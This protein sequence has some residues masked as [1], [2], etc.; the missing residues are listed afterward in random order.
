MDVEK[1]LKR[2]VRVGTVTDID[3]AKRKARVKF[4]DCNMTSGWLYVLDTHPHIPAY[5]PA[6]QKTELQDGHQHDL[7]IKPWMPLVNDT[8]LT[9]YLP[10]RYRMIVGALGDVV[11]SVSSR[12][13]KTISNF[14]WSGSARYATH[15]LHAGNSISEYTGTDLAKITFDIQLLASLGV[16]PMSE[17][18]RLFD[19]ERQ[20][21]TLPL[22]IGNHGYGRYRWTIL[23][24]KTKAE[25]YDGHGNI[26]SATLSISLQEYLR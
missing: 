6:Q 14:V 13:L 4:Q 8:V 12:T 9:L 7:T 17:I 3:N 23:S 18:W 26:I 15:D 10:V 5:D 1:V 19:L 20:G 2:L 21:V 22:T 25:H 24:H 16:D 11:F